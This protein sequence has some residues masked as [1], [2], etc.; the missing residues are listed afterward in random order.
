MFALC[1]CNN[2]YASCER[3]FRPDLRNR[4]VLVLSNNDG[5]VVA[6]SNEVKALGI[7]MGEP[8]FK[9]KN[10]VN[11]N[12]IA[13]FSSNYELYADM[14]NRV[15]TILSGYAPDTEIYSIDEM[16]LSFYGMQLFNLYDYGSEI[17]TTVERSTGIPVCLGIA[18]TK[19]LA[20]LANRFAKKHPGYNR[21]C[22]IDTTNKINKALKLTEVGDIWGIGSRYANKLNKQGI[23]TAYDFTQLPKPWVRKNMS[24]VGEK[25]W[26]ELQ[27]VSC[28]ALE[29]IQ[30][31][32]KQICT[33][34]S[35]GKPVTELDD[36]A[37]AV[38]Q[39]AEQCAHKL[40]KQK[41]AACSLMVFISTNWFNKDLPQYHNAKHIKLPISSAS[42]TDIVHFARIAL[43]QI[44][45]PFFQ[46]K[47]AGVI[48]TEI[49]R[50]SDV[51]ANLF[52][53]NDH[54]K[55]ERLMKAI[56]KINENNNRNLIQTAAAFGSGPQNM[57]RN[58]LSPRY[59]TNINDIIK[60]KP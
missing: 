52:L 9:I 30:P 34:R 23:I 43:E 29:N 40:R 15:M 1:D 17:V 39:Y 7:K 44:Y 25:I 27:G 42:T 11:V 16:F 33:S 19:T 8:L 60:I 54:A 28:L 59:T 2:F 22:I 53:Q 38:A 45:R 41:S 49:C 13:V 12:N 21:V 51:Q 56:D 5:C 26:S 31:D 20:K 46:Y 18:P 36:L 55:Q 35:F 24:V 48:I 4:P 14:S 47:K 58:K 3:V 32:K 37:T 10:L 6:R 50:A 57:Q